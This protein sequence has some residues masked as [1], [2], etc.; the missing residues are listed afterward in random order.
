M[1]KTPSALKWL[2]E[3][4]ARLAFDTAQTGRLAAELRERHERLQVQLA[5]LD[6]TL[7]VFDERIEPT[8]IAPMATQ[9]QHG[10]RGVVRQ[11]LLRYLTSSAPEWTSTEYLEVRF[12]ADFGIEF[13]SAAHRTR[14]RRNT[15]C[16]ALRQLCK[17]GLT[18]RLH[19]PRDPTGGL[20]HWRLTQARTP[21]LADL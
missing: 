3:K 20:G 16:S 9:G 5:A 17:A 7:K 11:A 19:D 15:L 14:W 10:R 8:A 13:E 1:N 21:S 4:R 6:T 12:L 2:A 18:E